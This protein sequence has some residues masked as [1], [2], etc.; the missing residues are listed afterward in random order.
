M[1]VAELENIFDSYNNKFLFPFKKNINLNS[2]TLR[3][4]RIVFEKLISSQY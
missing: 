3:K 2:P 1:L 4:K